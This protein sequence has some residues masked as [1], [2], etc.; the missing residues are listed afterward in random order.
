MTTPTVTSSPRLPG[1]RSRLS[2]AR[3]LI[4][5][6]LC[7]LVVVGF[8]VDVGRGASGRAPAAASAAGLS[9]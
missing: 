7:A 4:V 1:R 5:F 6:G 8:L 3:D 9:S 2:I